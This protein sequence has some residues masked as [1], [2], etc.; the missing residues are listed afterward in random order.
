MGKMCSF[1]DCKEEVPV[2]AVYCS[3]HYDMLM[4]VERT[5]QEQQ[6]RAPQ[7]AVVEP[8]KIP[9]SQF[10]ARPGM[11]DSTE[12]P[13]PP[14]ELKKAMVVD[15]SVDRVMLRAKCLEA[16]VTLITGMEFE[17]QTYEQLTQQAKTLTNE[18]EA[19]VLDFD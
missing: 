17:N 15:P 1:K 5:K 10:S 11:L 3:T 14:K 8:P 6:V 2:W 7:M 12:L 13:N 19:I 9:S 4:Q 18:F 16:A